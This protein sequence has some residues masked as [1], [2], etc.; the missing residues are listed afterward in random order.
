MVETTTD[1]GPGGRRQSR[2]S[3]SRKMH[4]AWA[5]SDASTLGSTMRPQVQKPRAWGPAPVLSEDQE[6]PQI[7]P[8]KNWQKLAKNICHGKFW[9][10]KFSSFG[11]GVYLDQRVFKY[12]ELGPFEQK[13]KNKPM[14]VWEAIKNIYISKAKPFFIPKHVWLK[15]M[16][17][18]IPLSPSERNSGHLQRPLPLPLGWHRKEGLNGNGYGHG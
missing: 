4:A 8:C 14:Q 11:F 18:F 12:G 13:K 2:D 6:D 7:N 9:E 10:E 16:C 3:P 17:I 1:V 5:H 15:N